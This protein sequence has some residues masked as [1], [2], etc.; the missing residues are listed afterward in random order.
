MKLLSLSICIG[1][2]CAECD[3][4]Y[5]TKTFINSF[6]KESVGNSRFLG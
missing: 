1:C 4:G 2:C 6:D 5:E 3:G